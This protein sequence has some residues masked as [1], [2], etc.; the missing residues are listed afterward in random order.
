MTNEQKLTI[1]SYNNS[2]EGFKTKI[3]QID[4]YNETYDYIASLLSDGD[5]VLDLACGPAQIPKFILKS[6]KVSVTGV[7]LSDGMLNIAREEIPD[8]N[9]VNHSIIDYSDG[10]KYDAC[11]LGFG[12]PY[13]SSDETNQCIC[14]ASENI[15]DG[16]YFYISFMSTS[17]FEK[18]GDIA[19]G[20]ASDEL[21]FD[22]YVNKGAGNSN[23]QAAIKKEVVMME[24]TSFGGD[25]LF[26]IHYHNKDQIVEYIKKSGMTIIKE[27]LL[28]YKESDG[29]VTEDVIFIARLSR[30]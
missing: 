13:L 30:S 15:A 10:K 21:K 12:I 14:N 7:D 24:K 29:S 11:I 2:A 22:Y 28:P 25:N 8:G 5:E 16:G 9:F 3:S 1:E 19:G 17:R 18:T 20:I 4:N 26:E 27:F 23:E 6:K